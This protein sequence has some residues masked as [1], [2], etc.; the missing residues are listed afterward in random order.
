M[1]LPSH[2]AESDR[3]VLHRLMQDHPLSTLITQT[4]AG[5]DANH[6]PLIL[7]VD[8]GEHGV[9]RGHVARANPVWKDYL[10]TSD[11]LAVFQGADAYI[12]PSW[13]P[14][15]KENGKA[16]PTWNYAV[17]HASGP[18]RIIDDAEWLRALVTR[19]TTHHEAAMAQPWSVGDAP[20]DYIDK[21]IS[22]IVGIEIPITKL[23]GKW[24]VSQNQPVQNR[25]GVVD[26]LSS[27]TQSN[28]AAMA[29][30]V[31]TDSTTLR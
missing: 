25:A 24:K 3:Q 6:I 15:K 28:V 7:S 29:A 4:S 16:V 10:S 8:E 21:M 9:L 22:A 17:V 20:A 5:L 19:L 23:V 14:T 26:G 12:S 30:L 27:S 31:A 11:V 1:Y 18:L 2:F 13:Y